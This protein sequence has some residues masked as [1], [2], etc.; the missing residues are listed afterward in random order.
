MTDFIFGPL[1]K[2]DA[3]VELYRKQRT[4]VWH[5]HNLE[6]R[7]P[8][9]GDRPVI[10]VTVA[11]DQAIES[12]RCEISE[13]EL[14]SLPMRLV[15]TEWDVINWRYYQIWQAELPTQEEGTIV[16]YKIFA[17]PQAGAAP[18]AADAGLTFSYLV[19][20]PSQPDWAAEA[21]I[22]QIFPDRFHPGLGRDW[23]PV[24]SLDE[25]HGGTIRG[26]IDQLDYIA[27]LGFNCLWLNPFFPDHTYHGYHAT[28]Y[29]SVNPRLGTNEEMHELVT[30]AHSRGIRMVLDFVANH[31]GSRHPTFQDAVSNYDSQYHDWYLWKTWPTD[32]ETYFTVRDL[33]KINLDFGPARQYMLDAA[34]FWLTEYDFDGLRL[35]YALGPSHDFWTDFRATIQRV[36]PDVWFFG[37]VTD[38]PN[39]QLSYWGKFQGCLDFLLLQALRETFGYGSMDLASFDAFLAKHEAYFPPGFSRPSFLDNHDMNRFLWIAQVDQRKLKLAALCQFTLIGQPIVYYGTE[40]GLSQNQDMVYPDGTHDMAEARLPMV[41]GAGQDQDLHQFYRQLIHFRR[42]HPVLWHGKR[43]TIY[44]DNQAGLYAYRR[45][46]EQESVTA[47]FNLSNQEQTISLPGYHFRLAPWSGDIQID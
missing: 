3:R 4:G 32:Y 36:K 15:A 18:L 45:F 19:G 29:F 10:T 16:R 24:N 27:D 38:L 25:P 37:E 28:D 5:H 11:V 41:W 46:N 1:N 6:P 47:A 14:L 22:Y 12:V 35:D 7:A 43:E 44:L 21:I 2:L 23:L 34:T 8:R 39:S 40:V 33:P 42:Q 9:P 20:E 30:A 13:P 26:I 31:W 17:F